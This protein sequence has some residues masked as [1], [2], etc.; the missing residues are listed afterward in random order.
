MGKTVAILCTLVACELV[1]GAALL[2]WWAV[3]PTASLPR[4]DLSHLDAVSA[5]EVRQRQQQVVTS[6]RADDWRSLAESYVLYG[7]FAEAD[8][9][10]RRAAALDPQEFWTYLWW[11]A[12]LSRLGRTTD[13]TATFRAAIPYAEGP[14]ADVCRYCIGL[15]LL[16]EE[17]PDD[18]EAAF[19]TAMGYA[20]ADYELAKLLVRSGRAAKAAPIL[21]GLIARHPQTEK[22]LQLRARAARLLDDPDAALDFQD[23]ADRATL[24]L[25]SDELTGFLEEQ[26][27]KRG[28]DEWIH[29]GRALIDS[30]SLSAGAARLSDVLAIEWRRDAADLLAQSE[31]ALGHP[32]RAIG[33]LHEAVARFGPTPARLVMLGDA[34]HRQ[35]NDE[36]ARKFWER[37]AR[38]RLDRAA[39]ERLAEQAARTGDEA[40]A[41]RH[42]ARAMLAAGIEAERIHHL[43]LAVER[44]EQ[45]VALAPQLAHAWYHLGE[46]RRLLGEVGPAEEAYRQCL[47]LDPNHGRAQRSLDRLLVSP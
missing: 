18:A 3:S 46:C 17:Q 35:G 31:L 4:P 6:D 7:F 19:R 23:R 8:A 15:N 11:G 5:R 12:A 41:A 43:D 39:H 13:S 37:A 40:N 2:G 25:P 29:E 38:L 1:M 33:I 21:D 16:R 28:L 14:L 27:G 36:Q 32:E 24:V 30:G 47:T 22:Y 20:P 44:L 34:F 10:C 26:I 9:C 42:H 45:T